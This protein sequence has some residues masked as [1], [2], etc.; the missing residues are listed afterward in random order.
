M[1]FK[2]KSVSSSFGKIFWKVGIEI[3]IAIHL[4]NINKG[5]ES[6]IFNCCV[7]EL[8][9]RELISTTKFI[10]STNI[11]FFFFFFLGG[12]IFCTLIHECIWSKFTYRLFEELNELGTCYFFGVMLIMVRCFENNRHSRK[13]FFFFFF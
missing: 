7:S 3:N 2:V 1:K 10:K 4:K 5:W 8:S 6:R 12:G 11:F 13:H 9:S